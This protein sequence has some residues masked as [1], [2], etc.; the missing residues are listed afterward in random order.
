MTITEHDTRCTKV[1]FVDITSLK[2]AMVYGGAARLYCYDGHSAYERVGPAPAPPRV[3]VVELVTMLTCGCGA[4]YDAG[5]RRR[6]YCP[7]C[8]QK[9]RQQNALKAGLADRRAPARPRHC[10]WRE[11]DLV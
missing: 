9:V 2:E 5:P 10:A 1:L 3:E 7:P 11:C 6:K 4:D 8:S